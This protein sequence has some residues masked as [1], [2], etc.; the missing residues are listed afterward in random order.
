MFLTVINDILLSI[1][2]LGSIEKIY[3][4]QGLISISEMKSLF[5]NIAHS[6]IMRLNEQSMDKVIVNN[7][8]LINSLIDFLF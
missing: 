6:S 1:F 4:H 3:K 2:N 8:S 7:F 5:T